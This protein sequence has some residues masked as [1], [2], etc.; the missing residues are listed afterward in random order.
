MIQQIHFRK[1]TSKFQRRISS[2]IFTTVVAVIFHVIQPLLRDPTHPI[3]RAEY[4]ANHVNTLSKLPDHIS[5]DEATT[6]T[7]AG[8]SLYG[9]DKAGGYIP[10]DTI[11]VLGPGSIGLMAV[12]CCKALAPGK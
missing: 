5:M 6:I 3:I 11:A 10:G 7:T 9:I 4:A 1:F 12:Q 8:T 2:V